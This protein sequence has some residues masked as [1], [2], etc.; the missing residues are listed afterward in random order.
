[1]QRISSSLT[2]V[3]KLGTLYLAIAGLLSAAFFLRAQFFVEAAFM[4]V[5]GF[6]YGVIWYRYAQFFRTVYLSDT[7]LLVSPAESSKEIPFSTIISISNVPWI[8]FPP[9]IVKYIAA[10]H[11][12]SLIFI[13]AYRLEG[14]FGSSKVI[15][16]LRSRVKQVN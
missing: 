1:V 11:E 10:G 13:P 3:F 14:I 16:M 7:G 5:A 6:A 15:E 8:K 9:L 4:F 12:Q 2:A